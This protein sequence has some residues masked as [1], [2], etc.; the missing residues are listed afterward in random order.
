MAYRHNEWIFK[1]SIEHEYYFDGNYGAKGERRSPKQTKTPE[2]VREENQKTKE[3]KVRRLIKQNFEPGDYFTTL[4]FSDQY[5]GT[6]ITEVCRILQNFL[7][8]MRRVYK[9][10]GV[11]FKYI[12]RVEL[13]A[14]KKRPHVHILMNRIDNLD[15]IVRQKWE[16]GHIQIEPMDKDPDSPGKLA[17]YIT[18]PTKEQ[19]IEADSLCDGDISKLIRYSCS[20][21]LERPKPKTQVMKNRTMH[22]VFN[23]DLKPRDGYY[24]D[25]DPRFLTR[26]VNPYTGKSYL[27]YQEIRLHKPDIRPAPVRIC[28]CP[29]CHQYKFD[30]LE[31]TCQIRIRRKGGRRRYG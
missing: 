17:E 27:T 12:Y 18:K 15:K 1:E 28:E 22:S 10:T 7:E 14:R 9:K 25:K 21:N 19:Q 11:P 30:E 24:I 5:I 23:Q 13:G 3:K 26:G 6:P 31:C 4:T 8:R 29:V 16:R 20:R 2:Q